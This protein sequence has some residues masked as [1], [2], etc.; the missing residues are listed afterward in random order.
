MIIDGFQRHP[1]LRLLVPL[2]VGIWCGDKFPHTFSLWSYSIVFF[3]LIIVFIVS[4]RHFSRWL[5]GVTISLFLFGIGFQLVSWQLGRTEYAFPDK[6]AVYK[7]RIQEEPEIKERSMQCHSVL[8]DEYRQDTTLHNRQGNLFLLYFPKDSLTSSLRRGDE[9]L[10][11][12]RLSLPLNNGNPDEFD[13]ARFLKRKGIAGTAYVAAGHWKVIGYDSSRTFRQMALDYREKIVACYRSLGFSKDEL[14]VV[15]ALTVGDKE[16]LSDDIVETYSVTGA[17]HVLALSGLHIGFI[18]ALLY[19]FFSFLWKRWR[20][21]KPFL[22]L[23]IIIF[24]WGFAFLTGLSSS[25]VRSVIMFS[26]LAVACLQPEKPL[27]LNTLAATAFLM[28]LYRPLWLFDVGFQLSF[29]AVVAIVVIQPKLY[30]LWKVDNR[31]LRYVWGLVTVSVAAQLGTAPL[32][33]FYF[34]RFSTHFLLT[35]LWVIPMVS[36]VLYSTVL[37][38]MLMPFPF[39]QQAFAGVVEALVR[40]QNNVLHWIEQLPFAS[41]DGI[42]MDVWEVVLFYLLVVM[43]YRVFSRCTARNVCLSLCALLVLVSYHTASAMLFTP[44][45][46]LEFYN[47]RGCPAV[48]C[49]TE[50]SHSWM[51]Y[52]DSLPD[53]ARMQRTLSSYW[54]HLGLDEPYTVTKDFSMPGLSVRNQLLCYAGKRVCLLHDA[55]WKDKVTN[56]PIPIDYLYISKGYKDNIKELSLLFSVKTVVLDSSLSAHNREKLIHECINLGISYFSLSEKGSVCILL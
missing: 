8:V 22:L 25:V 7:V 51:V 30:A 24:L 9:L 13:Y 31:F 47:V 32:V 50:G 19:F 36:L 56:H 55:R 4:N 16:E 43:A 1:F 18:Y 10:I 42:W 21:L 23:G 15:S 17:S 41:I 29:S 48:H 2:A 12:A 37:L 3:L 20:Y 46:C 5:Y 27:T 52:A 54:N 26:F 49:M 14:A 35:N 11:S 40:I 44:H 53:T 34:S 6:E 38:L 39:L 45:R 33:M 28:L